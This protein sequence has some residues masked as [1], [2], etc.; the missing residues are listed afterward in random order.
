VRQR[1]AVHGLTRRISLTSRAEQLRLYK[2]NSDHYGNSYACHEN[3]LM[4]AGA[5][6]AL[7]GNRS[8][9]I[10][11][12][13]APFLVSRIVYCGAGKVGAENGSD[14]IPYQLSQRADFFESLLGLQTT[15]N[16]PIVNTRDEPGWRCACWKAT[17]LMPLVWR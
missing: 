9:W 1:L 11:A 5:Y 17:L 6:T 3:Y 10:S 15:H 7:F 12:Y 4:D 14:P 13:I 8:E 2:N 16:R